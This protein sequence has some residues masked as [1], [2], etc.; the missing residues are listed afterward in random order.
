MIQMKK[1]SWKRLLLLMAPAS[2]DSLHNANT[3][4]LPKDTTLGDIEMIANN[5]FEELQASYE[6]QPKKKTTFLRRNVVFFF[7]LNDYCFFR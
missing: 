2:N 1:Y 3:K 6:K 5:L 4:S 7:G